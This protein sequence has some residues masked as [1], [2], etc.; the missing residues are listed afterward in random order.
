MTIGEKI[1]ILRKARGYSQEQLGLS[2][3]NSDA[4]VSR[5]SV[6]E[7]ENGRS[8][9][10]LENIKALA[11]LLDVS[12]DALLD[13]ELDLNDPETLSK[14][15]SKTSSS[16]GHRTEYSIRYFIYEYE[17]FCKKFLK[18]IIIGAISILLIIP[19]AIL[20]SLSSG[21]IN[22]L[23]TTGICVLIVSGAALLTVVVLIIINLGEWLKSKD[24]RQIALLDYRELTI[25]PIKNDYSNRAI[26]L[27]ILKITKIKKLADDIK[28]CDVEIIVEEND[29]TR[30]YVLRN[31]N[32]PDRLITVFN[33]AK[34][35]VIERKKE[36]KESNSN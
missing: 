28:H 20:T 16:R 23:F 25:Y 32:N 13:E 7:W 21:E 1:S 2:L 4:G 15:I 18:S 27:P 19:G 14:V 5:Q 9:P 10:K 36:N 34:S 31:V 26:F 24:G 8:E 30:T 12:F 29:Q 11:K 3:S 17:S 22:A 6:S 33:D 35:F